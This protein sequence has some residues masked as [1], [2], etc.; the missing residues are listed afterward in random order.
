VTLGAKEKVG[1]DRVENQEAGAGPLQ[2]L[3]DEK[4]Q[5]TW[6]RGGGNYI[7]TIRKDK[8]IKLKF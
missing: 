6:I 8:R 3:V 4:L 7:P 1:G 5:R 2:S